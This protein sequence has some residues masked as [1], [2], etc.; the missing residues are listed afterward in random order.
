MKRRQCIL[1]CLAAAALAL[2]AVAEPMT[3]NWPQFRG[4]A[5]DGMSHETGLLAEWPEGGPTELWRHP[6][7]E[8]YSAVSVAG[9]KLYSMYAGEYQIEGLEA[10][11]E[12][13]GDD[14]GMEIVAEPTPV[15]YA[16][17][18]D[19]ESGEEIWSTVIGEKLDTE[20]GN[21]PRSTPAV[22]D[23]TVYVLGSKG[24]LAALA[25]TGGEIRW[26]VKLTETFGSRQPG[27]GFSGSVLVDGDLLI[28]EGGGPEGKSFAGLDKASGEVRWTTGEAPQGAGYNS[29]QAIDMGGERRYLYIAGGQL[30]AIDHDG[31]EVFSHPFQA[32]ESHGM[33]IYVAPDRFFASGVGGDNQGAVM[34]RVTGSGEE[35]KV[36]E[37]WKAPFMRNHFSSSLYHGG[38][39]YGFDNS[40]FKCISAE[41]GEQKWA[42]R[43]LGKGSLIYADGNLVVLSDR[44]K[45]LLVE[46]T[47]EAYNEKGSVQAL[48]GKCWTAPTLAGGKLYLRSHT[49]MVSYDVAAGGKS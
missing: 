7:G 28:V 34:V 16:A 31:N 49:E 2:S 20:F 36:E 14:E 13:E 21:G 32:F 46:A 22:D 18:F 3:E 1:I 37:L 47:S 35:A 27:W 11:I 45:L 24:D 26:S 25:I 33:P 19:A 40:T 6:L 5:R 43:G 29:P 10:T 8:G 39:I 12:M 41:T 4:A 30:R 17:A 9:G 15:E 38:H 23:D 44:G 42:K 48:G